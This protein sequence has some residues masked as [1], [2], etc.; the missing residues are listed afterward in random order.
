MGSKRSTNVDGLRDNEVI[1]ASEVAEWFRE[2]EIPNVSLPDPVALGRRVALVRLMEPLH[3][4][5]GGHFRGRE[6]ELDD[7]RGF[8]SGPSGRPIVHHGVGG[9]GKSALLAK[10]AIE[11]L[12]SR[13]AYVVRLDFD[14]RSLIPDRPATLL[15]AIIEQLWPQLD[16]TV[17]SDAQFSKLKVALGGTPRDVSSLVWELGNV[18]SVTRPVLCILDTLEQVQYRSRALVE[19]LWRFL[20]TLRDAVTS[21]RIVI[22]SRAPLLDLPVT[23]RPLGDLDAVAAI[24]A[25]EALGVS[26]EA[27][28]VV[29]PDTGG[30][31]L[32]LRMVAELLKRESLSSLSK[33]LSTAEFKA[34]VRE[35]LV[36]GFLFKR[37]LGHVGDENV[38]RI[39]APSLVLRRITPEII[40]EVLA[41]ACDLTL[42]RASSQRLFLSLTAET[43]LVVQESGDVLRHRDELRPQLLALLDSTLVTTVRKAAVAY[44]ARQG[45][46]PESRAEEIYHLLCLNS[47]EEVTRE[48]LGAGGRTISPDRDRR[49]PARGRRLPHESRK[50]EAE[51]R[52]GGARVGRLILEGGQH[53]PVGADGRAL[54]SGPHRQR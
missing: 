51:R 47:S 54:G 15:R 42:D 9:V 48:A 21:L 2:A 40:R 17:A 5:V 7:L 35:H 8:V 11:C 32:A 41:P 45:E 10:L 4:L 23:M 37:I 25:L 22:A 43:A 29:Q 46:D 33:A 34:K 16:P 39:A 30:N 6:V 52:L 3:K 49:A 44:Y 50:R 1:D 19:Q 27:A 26:R 36:E 28:E 14:R 53:T 18:I 38:K 13:S 24:S 20:G 31:P 12:G